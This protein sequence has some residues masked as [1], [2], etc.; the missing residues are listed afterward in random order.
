MIIL[1][2][3]LIAAALLTIAGATP[4]LAQFGAGA[5]AGDSLQSGRRNKGAAAPAPVIQPPAL[6]G[7]RTSPTAVAP[8][9]RIPTDMA[10]T[11]AL[12]DAINRG[13]L[14][15]SR[16]AIGRGA[17][18]NARNILGLTPIELSIDLGRTEISFLLLS[19]R[20]ETA[21]DLKAQ[22]A[23]QRTVPERT[24]VPVRTAVVRPDPTTPR[25]F[26]NDGGT[27]IPSVGF[28]GFDAGRVVR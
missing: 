7:V 19:Y 12:F 22:N 18:L 27:P 25:L 2:R 28:M 14:A 9:S 11:D 8:A 23:P 20:S 6:P 17:D 24:P 13:D 21:R 3:S 15:V 1:S 10:P 26:A 4:C 16:D 5:T